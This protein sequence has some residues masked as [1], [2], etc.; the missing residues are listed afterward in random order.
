MSQILRN[1]NGYENYI[2]SHEYSFIVKSFKLTVGQL[3]LCIHI[4]I[5]GVQVPIGSNGCLIED[6]IGR[7]QV[8]RR[9]GP[10]GHHLSSLRIAA[11]APLEAVASCEGLG[12]GKRGV[13]EGVHYKQYI[14]GK[15]VLTYNLF[16]LEIKIRGC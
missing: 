1:C 15:F 12:R 4:R 10:G 16:L 6:V 8:S 9:P 3:D 11:S 5:S 2:V 7:H 14:C 13:R